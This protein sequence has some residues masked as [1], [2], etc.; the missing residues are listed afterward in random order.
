[1]TDLTLIIPDWLHVIYNAITKKYVMIGKHTCRWTILPCRGR[2]S[3]HPGCR[4]LYA[5]TWLIRNNSGNGNELR[6]EGC[7]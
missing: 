5:G 2:P 3:Q 4:V 7:Q 6:I 1:M